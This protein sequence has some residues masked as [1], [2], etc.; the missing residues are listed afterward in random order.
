MRYKKITAKP[1]KHACATL[2][3][4]GDLFASVTADG[5]KQQVSE[6]GIGESASG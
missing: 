4:N 2:R 3:C 5:R 1:R 6:Q